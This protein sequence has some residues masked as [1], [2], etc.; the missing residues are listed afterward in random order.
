LLGLDVDDVAASMVLLVL[1]HLLVLVLI[2]VI[3]IIIIVVVTV[4][5]RGGAA[6]ASVARTR[7]RRARRTGIRGR[8]AV[9]TGAHLVVLARVRVDANVTT[10]PARRRLCARR[11]R[12]GCGPDREC[13][14]TDPSFP[15]AGHCL[16]HESGLIV[17]E[18]VLG[19]LLVAGICVHAVVIIHL[20]GHALHERAGLC[21]RKLE[22]RTPSGL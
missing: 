6:G 8:R 21:D 16:H 22:R 11:G 12:G 7:R 4:L 3:V 1:V 18:A 10:T 15:G 17:R 14:V 19:I 9:V 20:D 5:G 13:C 2:V